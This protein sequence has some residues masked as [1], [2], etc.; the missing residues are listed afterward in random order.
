M[1]QIITRRS[2]YKALSV[3]A[4]ATAVIPITVSKVLCTPREPEWTVLNG[5]SI[6]IKYRYSGD[7]KWKQLH[8]SAGIQE[9]GVR[10]MQ[11]KIE[12]KP[13]IAL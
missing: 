11:I 12:F 8:T 3:V 7:T 6:C 1:E 13:T 4:I 9:Y 10:K 2:F 5:N